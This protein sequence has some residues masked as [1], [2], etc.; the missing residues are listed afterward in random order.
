MISLP[1]SVE[2]LSKTARQCSPEDRSAFPNTSGRDSSDLPPPAEGCSDSPTADLATLSFPANPGSPPSR[3]GLPGT[4]RF[5]PG[6][7]IGGRFTVVRYIDRGG[8]GEVYEVE[9]RFLQDIRVALKMIRPEVA[10]DSGS[11]RRF[12]RE[13]LLARKVTHPNLCPIYD[14]ARCDD[15]PPPFLFLT[16]KLLAGET[17]SSR[18]K[19]PEAISREEAIAI[20]RQLV[21]GLAAIHAAGI[22]HRDI[23]PNNVM[24]DY[25]GPEVCVSI[26]DFGLARLH[27][28]E[29]T[30]AAGS[31]IAGTPGYMPPEILLGQGP[32]QAADFFALGVLL[33]QVLTRESPRYTPD[34]ATIEPS[35]SIDSADVPPILIHA[36]KEL[37]SNDT[38]RRCVAFEQ[39]QTSYVGDSSG[40]Q[41]ISVRMFASLDR[42]VPQP[43]RR[44]LPLAIGLL[45]V[46]VLLLDLL[47]I[48]AIGD[49]VR[50]MLFSSKEKHIAVLPLQSRGANTETQLIEDGLMDS[51]SGSL[52]NLSSA[53]NSL[54]VVP[55]NDVRKSQVTSASGALHEFGATLV[56]Q[57]TFQRDRDGTRLRLSLIDARKTREIGYID[58]VSRD[59]DLEALQD[60]A[61]TRLSR[62]LNVSTSEDADQGAGGSVP[63]TAYEDY[64]LALGYEQRFDKSVNLSLADCALQ[65]A[66]KTD[67]GFALARAH[68]AQIDV[69][70]Y[71]FHRNPQSSSTDPVCPSPVSASS[72]PVVWLDEA[73]LDSKR[74]LQLDPAVALAHVA[75][76]QVDQ[77]RGH[78]ELALQEFHKA[79]ELDAGNAAALTELGRFYQQ[80]ARNSEAEAFYRKAADL[81][82][83][84]WNG[85][86]NLG[87]F[88]L[89]TGRFRDAITLF[90]RAIS[91]A[92]D[93]A[94]AYANLGAAY[95]DTGDPKLLGDAEKALG[96]SI[97]LAPNYQAYA[98]LANLYGEER[99]FADSVAASLHALKL[100]DQDYDVWNNLAQG[101]EWLGDEKNADVARQ[102]ER[103]LVDQAIRINAQDADAQ[104]TLAVLLA[105]SGLR[106]E[107]QARIQI[108]L[109]TSPSDPV[110]LSNV[111][112]AYEL[113]GDRR[114]GIRYLEQALSNGLPIDDVDTDPYARGLLHDPALHIPKAPGDQ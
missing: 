3:A 73:E 4:G 82:P 56:V 53:G 110:V 86:M 34:G 50:G 6:Q 49:R 24:L 104:S 5:E 48:P 44:F 14:I 65:D 74:A 83:D 30:I 46:A 2:Q 55:S 52:S 64:L 111:A 61:V 36:I 100:N 51:L 109:D 19:T 18:L 47:W 58:L 103:P 66:L 72:D 17:L 42:F 11:S 96:M 62:L 84:D 90:H 97:A 113:L 57:G 107:S 114:P 105:K 25:S 13:V 16:M 106:S 12:E 54:W 1:E 27:T 28:A 10:G 59:N 45:C 79:M 67:P 70:L 40:Q 99:R 41:L 78:Q 75:L 37:I 22:I 77:L 108:A 9:D 63:R 85:F 33:H 92:P 29:T 93:S 8:M 91:L 43:L 20:S 32:S 69:L 23:K 80:S 60:E 38:N 98:D 94:G 21:G 35:P 39:M 102:R 89:E 112:D 31:L 87:L 101:Y 88:Y 95:L 71:R 81:H 76:G 7:V 15:P 26:M 68:L